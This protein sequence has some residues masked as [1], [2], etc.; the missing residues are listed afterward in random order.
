MVNNHFERLQQDLKAYEE[1]ATRLKAEGNVSLY[2]KI[3]KKRDFIRSYIEE[4]GFLEA[5]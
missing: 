4:K 5:A 3:C 1:L 2:Q